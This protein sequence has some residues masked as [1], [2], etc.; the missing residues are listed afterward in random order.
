MPA[1]QQEEFA[2]SFVR[3]LSQRSAT[4]GSS[5]PA[6]THIPPA[7]RP[8]L[9]V[10]PQQKVL[11]ITAS[12]QVQ[13]VV[14]E[15]KSGNPPLELTLS[16]LDP[17]N[18]LRRLVALSSSVPVSAQRLVLAGK[19]LVSTKTLLDYGVK[20]QVTV[21]LARKPGT[22]GAAVKQASTLIIP[23]AE[24][25]SEVPSSLKNPDALTGEATQESLSNAE[26]QQSDTNHFWSSIKE[27]LDSEFGSSAL[28]EKPA[29]RIA[30]LRSVGSKA[31]L[32]R[33]GTPPAVVERSLLQGLSPAQPLAQVRSTSWYSPAPILPDRTVA[34]SKSL[35]RTAPSVLRPAVVKR[36][37]HTQGSMSSV[38]PLGMSIRKLHSSTHLSPIIL[39]PANGV[40]GS[41]LKGVSAPSK[42]HI[43]R[44]LTKTLST[45]Q[46]EVKKLTVNQGLSLFFTGNAGTGK[47]FLMQEIIN[48]LRIKFPHQEQVAVTASTG[49][50]ACNIGG[51][52][53]H[54]FAGIGLGN[55]KKEDLATH[56]I[57][58]KKLRIRWERVK[59]L[60]ID[61]ISMID[62]H[63]FDKIEYIARTVRGNNLPFG[64]VQLVISGDFLQLPPVNQTPFFC[65]EAQTWTQAVPYTIMLNKVFRQKDPKFVSIL[66]QLRLNTLTPS[67]I[68]VLQGLSREP[69][70]DDGVEPTILFSTRLE[71]QQVNTA[72]LEALK[73]EQ[74]IFKATFSSDD[75]SMVKR[76]L[77]STIA[78]PIVSLKVGAQVMLIKNIVNSYVNGSTGVIE[79][80]DPA[81]GYP[82]VRFTSKNGLD[83]ATMICSA[84]WRIEGPDGAILGSMY[85]IPLLLSYAMS[86]HKS[87]GQTLERVKVDM[88]RIFESG[89]AYVAL[90]RATSLE[91]LQVLN[92]RP[93]HAMVNSKVAQFQKLL[94][95]SHDEATRQ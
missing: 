11:D 28:T 40:T 1:Q 13:I 5:V 44:P 46:S 23:P 79:S 71:V 50:A 27:L 21:H 60:V 72:K 36:A 32:V 38:V 19:A 88:S 48:A 4:L 17:I 87:Q 76:L 73:T 35:S 34:D 91:R 80:F 70:Y 22:E 75:P 26:E 3:Q 64:G 78:L 65:F 8:K 41:T 86:I 94:E 42:S 25:P 9:I 12:H 81:T 62:G 55:G 57:R 90:S 24:S 66:N 63:L 33:I 15:L 29:V 59:V 89:Q 95:R 67:S 74:S 2:I 69:K 31:S 85:Q 51:C 58:N 16:R 14:K 45:E 43:V 61:E 37:R 47:S 53:L 92:F 54:S 30:A 6:S 93:E 49:I 84:E 77:N 68:E 18:E 56:I 20:K 39:D 7:S 82:N 10:I 83:P 52:T